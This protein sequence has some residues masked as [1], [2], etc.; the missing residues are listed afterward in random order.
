MSP[1]SCAAT[2]G[3]LFVCVCPPDSA[4]SADIAAAGAPPVSQQA[5]HLPSGSQRN[6]AVAAAKPNKRSYKRKCPPSPN[7][8]PLQPAPKRIRKT[9]SD[10]H[11][12][13]GP[14][15]VE[16]VRDEA[17]RF[18]K[19]SRMDSMRALARLT[20]YQL[21]RCLTRTYVVE[22]LPKMKFLL[23]VRYLQTL[24]FTNVFD[25]PNCCVSH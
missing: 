25:C 6:A 2:S 20:R 24:V 4:D 22:G 11:Q 23:V 12:K 21:Q 19:V 5:A 3:C 13:R 16:L 1:P 15:K 7:E 14:P 18:L 8:L 17:G 10:K 9:R